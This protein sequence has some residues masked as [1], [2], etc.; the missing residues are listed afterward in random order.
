MINKREF[1]DMVSDHT[2]RTKKEVEEW[3]TL[4]FEEVKRA[5]KLYGGLKIVNFGTFDT[6]DR[7]GRMGKNPNTQEDLYIKGRKVLHF[8]PGKEIR[9]IVNY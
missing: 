1:V 6:R 8:T 7:K 9:E 3:T 5:V 2:G 4:I